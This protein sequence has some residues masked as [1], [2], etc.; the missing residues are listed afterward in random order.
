MIIYLSS[1]GGRFFDAYCNNCNE[2][3]GNNRGV[4]FEISGTD[5]E[6]ATAY[7]VQMNPGSSEQHSSF[8]SVEPKPPHPNNSDTSHHFGMLTTRSEGQS[9]PWPTNNCAFSVNNINME[10]WALET[11]RKAERIE[12]YRGLFT[13]GRVEEGLRELANDP[14]APTLVQ[15]TGDIRLVDLDDELKRSLKEQFGRS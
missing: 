12:Y 1:P 9:T 7:S 5:T 10:T 4:T 8:A 6:N 15:I 13:E 2:G 11:R 3:E 14:Y